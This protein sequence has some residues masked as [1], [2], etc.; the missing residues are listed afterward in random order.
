MD[1]STRKKVDVPQRWNTI[2]IFFYRLFLFLRFLIY[3]YCLIGSK[4]L[5]TNISKNKLKVGSRDQSTQHKL[6]GNKNGNETMEYHGG[7]L[8]G[9]DESELDTKTEYEGF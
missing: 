4:N 9:V 2:K 5:I 6:L 3:E 8:E 7:F 1:L